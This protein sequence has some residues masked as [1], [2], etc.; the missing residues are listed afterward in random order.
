MKIRNYLTNLKISQKLVLTSIV[1]MSILTVVIITYISISSLKSTNEQ[2]QVQSKANAASVMEMIDRNFYERFGDVQAFAYNKLAVRTAMTDSV[3]QDAQDFINTMVSYYVLYD[4]MMITDINGKVVAVNSKDKNGNTIF[5][6]GI[7][8]QNVT[9]EEWFSACTS[10]NGPQGGAYYSD[11]MINKTSAYINNNN[12]WGMTFAAPI[13]DYKGNI[14]GVWYNYANWGEV[15]Q[16]IRNETEKAL[17]KTVKNSFILVTN[18]NNQVIDAEDNSLVVSNKIIE[19]TNF[20]NGLEF[21]YLGRT[22]STNNYVIGKEKGDGAYSYRGKNWNAI[23]FIPK[24]TFTWTYFTQHLAILIFV[25]ILISVII[26]YIFY[27]LASGIS[28]NID[29]VKDYMETL[30]KGK[31]LEVR[32]ENMGEMTNTVKNLVEGLNAKSKFALEIGSGNLQADYE[33]LSEEDILGKSLLNMRDN[34][35]K[36]SE[37]DSKRN[38]ISEGLAKFTVFLRDTTDEQRFYDTILSNLIRYIH[39]NQGYLYV[40]NEEDEN[41]DFL[42]VKSVYAYGKQRYLEEKKKIKWKQGLVG[43][44]WFDKEPLFF[45]EIPSDYV[46][47]TSGM[48]EATPTCVFII[49]LIIN[50]KVFGAIEIA[51]FE[52]LSTEKIEFVS[53]LSETIAST[54][55]TVKVNAK[56][57][58]LL[59][60]SQQQTEEMRAQEEEIRQNLEEMQATQSEMT[61]MQRHLQEEKIKLEEEFLAQSNIINSVAIVSRTDLQ[62]NITYVNDEFLKW[63]KYA[64]EE[65]MGKN[66]RILKSGDQDDQIFEDMWRTISS[67]NIFRGEIKNKAKDGSFYWVD[68][69]IAPILDKH[70]K[71]KEYIAQRFVINDKK[72][73]EAKLNELLNKK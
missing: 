30:S 27:R 52:P 50:E 53:K 40:I 66:H 9:H 15:T 34:L 44:A 8:G 14:I 28:K 70:G 39:A 72:E 18:E 23:T 46:N 61:R 22:I 17:R 63:S 26:C 59:N 25:I 1:V 71:P 41:D 62:G 67:G 73:N 45:T 29:A 16:G 12:G 51:S 10:G 19:E 4:L 55:S 49:P 57:K 38:W 64:K 35:V 3:K 48:G 58:M 47:I 31:L 69:I 43:Q 65:V 20:E 2:Y 7:I 33:T 6:K 54:I 24:A 56:T 13:R 68:A 11:F 5:S 60:Q 37:E 42:E 21:S 32:E 36:V